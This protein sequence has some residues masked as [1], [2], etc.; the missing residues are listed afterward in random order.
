MTIRVLLADDNEI[1][2]RGLTWIMD[3][4]P[5][6]EVCGEAVDG[7]EAVARAGELQ[8]DVVLLDVRMPRLDG[9]ESIGH[10]LSLPHPPRILMLTTFHEDESVRVAL[11]AG[12]AGFLLKDTPPDDLLRAIR[13]VHGGHSA[14]GP[15]VARR[16]V[17]GLADRVS[18]TDPEEGSRIASLT[19]REHEVLRL[20][21][22]GLTNTDIASA[23]GMTEGT[24]K[25]HVSSIL[26]KLGADSRVQAA[27]I[28][29]RTGLDDQA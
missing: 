19:P 2:R 25:G 8:P 13:D 24:V 11:R 3:S 28:A 26:A 18:R 12:A 14:L 15:P 7:Q 29:Y 5:D 20:L 27:R 22:R 10:L 4:S 16:L 1:T 17:D 23:L 6:I 9:L 21:A